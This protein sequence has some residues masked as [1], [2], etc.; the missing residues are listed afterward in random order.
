MNIHIG[1]KLA[2]L[3]AMTRAEYNTLRGWQLPADE[4]GADHGY[5]IDDLS[6]PANHPDYSGYISWAPKHVAEAQ[7]QSSDAMTF[8]AATIMVKEGHRIAR[9]GW[10]GAG[11]FVYY[12]PAAS[13]PASRNS[14]GVMLEEYPDGMVPYNH[15]LAIRL[16]DGTVSTWAPSCSDALANDW[17]LV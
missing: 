10:N 4:N 13:Y 6:A 3:T 8:G 16:P 1:T 12:I 17:E 15:Y 2:R 7:Y 9:K 11:Q 5:L 14:K